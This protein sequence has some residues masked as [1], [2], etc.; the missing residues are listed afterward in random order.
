MKYT[1]I[2][3]L[4]LSLAAQQMSGPT[5]GW[6]TNGRGVQA[7]EGVVGAARLGTV[8]EWPEDL[9]SPVLSPSGQRAA[10]LAGRTPYLVDLLTQQRTALSGDA[11]QFVWS[12][13]G[14]ALLTAD[15][16]QVKIFVQ[17]GNRYEALPEV[18]FAAERYAVSDDGTAIL[19]VVGDDLLLRT[20]EGTRIMGSKSAVYTFLVHSTTTAISEGGDL[21]IGDSRHPA[22]AGDLLLASPAPSR[23]VAVDRLTG[24]VTW[25]NEKG[26]RLAEASCQCEVTHFD[27]LATAGIIRLG[28]G[29]AEGPT[30]ITET[31]PSSNRLFFVPATVTSEVQE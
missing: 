15:G 31:T 16:G 24:N 21:L 17:R 18:N 2:P 12:P 8:R 5:L 26:I 19:A 11:D 30:W 22:P 28:T 3:F 1:W 6:A 7:I 27:F 29:T 20:A 14:T 4:A 9:S 13:A 10:A 23:L 25:L